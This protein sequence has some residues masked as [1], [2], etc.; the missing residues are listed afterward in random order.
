MSGEPR[1]RKNGGCDA[2]PRLGA[3]RDGVPRYLKRR[4]IPEPCF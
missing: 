4:R 3:S 1:E 2:Q